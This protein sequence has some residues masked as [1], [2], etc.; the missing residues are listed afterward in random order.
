[1]II[2]DRN[3]SLIAAPIK[4][5]C[6]KSLDFPTSIN[7]SKVC[8]STISA[9]W[10]SQFLRRYQGL[11][12][13]QSA[14]YPSTSRRRHHTKHHRQDLKCQA[15]LCLMIIASGHFKSHSHRKTFVKIM[16]KF[17]AYWVIKGLPESIELAGCSN[18]E[19]FLYVQRALLKSN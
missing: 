8:Q 5:A 18:C 15:L 11:I 2:R 9:P 13:F 1:M 6:I 7:T 14:P 4:V 16:T 10:S 3:C 17:I 19:I 12:Y